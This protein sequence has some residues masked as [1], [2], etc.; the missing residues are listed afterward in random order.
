MT[1]A[2]TAALTMLG[3]VAVAAAAQPQTKPA[4]GVTAAAPRLEQ[5]A[6]QPA[7]RPLLSIFGLPVV[8]NTPVQ[9]PYCNCGFENFAGQ[10]MRG[11]D[12]LMSRSI[13]GSP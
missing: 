12:E 5:R 4:L 7:P 3:M 6:R 1:R 2:L 13:A 8:L 10:P 9:S 11:G